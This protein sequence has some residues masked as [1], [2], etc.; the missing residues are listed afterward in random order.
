MRGGGVGGKMRWGKVSPFLKALIA[1]VFLFVHLQ[2][3]YIFRNELL[4]DEVEGMSCYNIHEAKTHDFKHF[5]NPSPSPPS[6]FPGAVEPKATMIFNQFHPPLP[7]ISKRDLVAMKLWIPEY[8]TP[9]SKSGLLPSE[10]ASVSMGEYYLMVNVLSCIY[11]GAGFVMFSID[12]PEAP[13]P[14]KVRWL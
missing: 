6:L 9:D 5:H 13:L 8:I 4:L 14:Q 2:L 7:R 10:T 1:S 3:D 11:V 12:H